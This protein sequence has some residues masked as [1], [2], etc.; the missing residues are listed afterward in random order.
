MYSNLKKRARRLWW[1]FPI[2][3][4]FLL[5]FLRW[6]RLRVDRGQAPV[7]HASLFSDCPGY[8]SGAVIAAVYFAGFS[9]TN[10]IS[11]RKDRAFAICQK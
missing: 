1:L 7:L 10:A 8:A 9:A 6:E 2:A 4:L 5:A 11:N 3:G